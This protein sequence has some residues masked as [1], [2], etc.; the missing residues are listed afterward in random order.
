MLVCRLGNGQ[1]MSAHL[2]D[3]HCHDALPGSAIFSLHML[4]D[5]RSPAGMSLVSEQLSRASAKRLHAL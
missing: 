3:L 5:T 1:S 2:D 4:Q